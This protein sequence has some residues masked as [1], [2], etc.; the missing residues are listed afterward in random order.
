[1]RRRLPDALGALVFPLNC[2]AGGN[3]Y[4][5]M[6]SKIIADVSK[7]KAT[8]QAFHI[9]RAPVAR[10]TTEKPMRWAHQRT[11]CNCAT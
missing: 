3:C 6:R 2:W 11:V 5:R 10:R 9:A 1:M 4:Y 7:H 8:P